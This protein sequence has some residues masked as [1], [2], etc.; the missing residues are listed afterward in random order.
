MLFTEEKELQPYE[1]L[2][3]QFPHDNRN[4][5]NSKYTPPPFK[6]AYADFACEYCLFYKQCKAEI[7][8]AKSEL[9]PELNIC[10]FIA[11]NLDDLM[12]D[13]EFIHA[14]A[15]AETCKT[16]HKTTLIRLKAELAVRVCE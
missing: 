7:K 11:D 13:D 3:K 8:K 5:G 9:E 12:H 10:S 1:R 14:I 6:Y 4:S 15:N 16:N 2:M